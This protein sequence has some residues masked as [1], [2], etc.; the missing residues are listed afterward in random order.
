MSRS[1]GWL[2]A[3]LLACASPEGDARDAQTAPAPSGPRDPSFM[4]FPHD[5]DLSAFVQSYPRAPDPEA[6]LDRLFALDPARFEQGA[7]EREQWPLAR[8]L[9][10]EFYATWIREDPQRA[11]ALAQRAAET[12]G[13]KAALYQEMLSRAVA[14]PVEIPFPIQSADW[15]DLLW[16][17][18][19]ASGDRE[20]VRQMARALEYAR[21]AEEAQRRMQELAT[22]EPGTPEHAELLRLT[23]AHAAVFG[24]L[25]HGAVDPGVRSVLREL[26][27]EPGHVGEVAASIVASLEF[28][29]IP[30]WE[31]SPGFRAAA[32][33]TDD[34]EVFVARMRGAPGS[35]PLPLTNHTS[36]GRAVHVILWISGCAAAA[37]GRCR[38]VADILV[39]APDGSVYAKTELEVWLGAPPPADGIQ[40]GRET[41]GLM[42]PGDA[43]PGRYLIHVRV[44]D[45]VAD[46]TLA[47]T[48]DLF[49]EESS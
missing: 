11:T 5:P 7:R 31:R 25:R 13:E 15:L 34:P 30:K 16:A 27:R 41:F 8:E 39:K 3:L 14:N 26:A 20:H 33:L 47:S 28:P 6:A 36:R 21:P 2:A 23:A 35:G 19:D 42:L 44:R 24:L 46:Q 29:Q 45:E 18:Y 40:L 37:D 12:S 32:L 10:I 22:S 9:L 38:T 43:K 1:W 17:R 48:L 4:L 49:L